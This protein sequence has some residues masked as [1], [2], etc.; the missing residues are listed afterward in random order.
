MQNRTFRLF[1]S[2][3]FS[4]FTQ[5]RS[6]L[7][8]IVFPEIKKY[9]SSN[10]LTFQPIDLRWGVSSEAQLDQKTLELCLNEVKSSKLNPHPNFL[11]MAGDRY[12]WIPLPYLIEEKEFDSILE[13]IENSDDKKLLNSWYKL[14]ENQIPSSHRMNDTRFK[15]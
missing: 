9:C 2:S 8:T 4:D 10:K 11:I 6:L 1:V 5:E 7:Q 13:N 3:T 15:D 14:D 12:G